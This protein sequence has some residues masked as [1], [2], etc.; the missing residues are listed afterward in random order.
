MSQSKL[1]C[2]KCSKVEQTEVFKNAGIPAALL[3]DCGHSIEG[4]SN[5]LDYLVYIDENVKKLTK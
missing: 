1:F 4:Q 5:I 3:F 2:P